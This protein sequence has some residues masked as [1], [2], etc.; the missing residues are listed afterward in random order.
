MP[1]A[2]EWFTSSDL[3]GQIKTLLDAEAAPTGDRLAVVHGDNQE[4]ILFGRMSGPPPAPVTPPDPDC[5]G[6]AGPSG[7]FVNPT[8]SSNAQLVAWQEDDGIWVG[9]VPADLSNCTGLPNP[10]LRIPGGREPDMS[11]A[12]ISPGARPGCGNPG[13]PVACTP[14]CPD[15][16]APVP[17]PTSRRSWPFL[18]AEAKKLRKLGVHGLRHKKRTTLTFAADQAGKFAVRFSGTPVVG[19]SRAS[20]LASGKHTF[21]AAGSARVTMKLTGK[22]ARALRRAKGV[23]GSLKATFTPAGGAPTT[24]TK[25]L[26]LPR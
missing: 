4:S 23:R 7:K 16:A 12:A 25:K 21:A 24:A 10:V 11:P 3:S 2:A 1:E 15:P 9:Q 26:R 8:W 19:A 20:L 22:G 5:L 18:A 13:N 14:N 17:A 6:Y